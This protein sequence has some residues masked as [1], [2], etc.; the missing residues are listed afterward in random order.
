[1]DSPLDLFAFSST[2]L[3]QPGPEEPA[4]RGCDMGTPMRVQLERI[5]GGIK[6]RSKHLR[7]LHRRIEYA[8]AQ[9]AELNLSIAPLEKRILLE[10]NS[11]ATLRTQAISLES[12]LKDEEVYERSI[13]WVN[14]SFPGLA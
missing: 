10:T 5:T 9:I 11:I 6:R 4:L 13:R 12:S 7:S 3:L 2:G 8:H 14:S 1:M